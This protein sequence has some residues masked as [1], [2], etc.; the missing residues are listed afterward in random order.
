MTQQ[1]RDLPSI[2]PAAP[3]GRHMLLVACL[4]YPAWLGMTAVHESGHVLHVWLSGGKVSHVSLP[5]FDFSRTDLSRNP[6]PQFVAWG[7]PIWGC[8]LPIAAWLLTFRAGNTVR[9]LVQLFAGFCL[10]AN[11]IYLGVGWVIGVGDAG[12]LLRHGAHVWELI[13]FGTVTVG[14]GLYLWH[15]VGVS[16]SKMNDP[17][18]PPE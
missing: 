16:R 4:L 2:Q 3:R 1:E 8:V 7:G 10:V 14:T 17:D 15:R 9:Q 11:G 5:L 12:D 6:H 18:R 13:A